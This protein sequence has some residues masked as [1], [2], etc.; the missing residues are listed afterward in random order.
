LIKVKE[1][2][3]HPRGQLRPTFCRAEPEW[4]E[5]TET[6]AKKAVRASPHRLLF[7]VRITQPF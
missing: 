1:K 5:L 4:A 2:S 3:R 7:G 6:K